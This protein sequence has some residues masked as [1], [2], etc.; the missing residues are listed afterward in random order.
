MKTPKTVILLLV[1]LL[2]LLPSAM[3]QSSGGTHDHRAVP[4]P[5]E[6][7]PQAIDRGQLSAQPG[8]SNI[9]VTLALS[10]RN[11]NDAENLLQAIN[12]PGNPRYQQFLTSDQFVAR[13]APADA[14][15]AR[16][17]A[18]LAKFGL[19]AQRTS[20]MTLSVTG[21]AANMERVFS[22]N[23]HSYEVPAHGRAAGYTY[24]APLNAPAIPADF[25]GAVTAVTGLDNRPAFRPRH[26]GVP[27]AVA[28]ARPAHAPKPS[29]TTTNDPGFLT[30]A[31]FAA[32]YDVQPLYNRGVTGKGRTLAIVT[33]AAF[34]PADAFAYWSAVGL[35][36]NANRIKIVNV[37]GGPG[38]PSDDSGSDETTL[39]VEQAGGIAPGANIIVY[40]APNTSQAFLDAFVQAVESNTAQSISTS[41]GEWEW[42]D[43][44]DNSPVTDP[45]TGK[46]VGFAQ[47]T[48]EVFLRAA[49][50]GQSVFAA[51]GDAGAYDVNR[52]CLPPD[53]T[54]TLSVDYPASDTLI[55]AAGGTTLPGLQE[56]CL[57][58][59]C[60]PPYF[61]INIQH[62]SVWGWD[63]LT[64]LCSTLGFDPISCG[65]FPAGGGGGVS[66]LF[67]RPLYQLFM[68]GMKNT[69]PNPVLTFEGELVFAV[70]ARYPGRNLP[71][72]SFNADPN[73]GY[74]IYY[75]SD[76]AGPIILTFIGGTSFVAP[77]LNGVTALL[78]DSL[79]GRRL[80]LLN[81]PLYLLALTGQAYRGAHPPMHAIAFGDNWFYKG[82]NGYNQ[83]AGLGT[84]DVANF[85][86]ALEFPF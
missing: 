53:C 6:R 64:N 86:K 68:P 33:L 34:T 10:L 20:A 54:V 11:V 15:V 74:I 70:P 84:L 4:Y 16:L 51:A 78:G 62:E 32:L 2:G 56:Y 23:L 82:T 61:D 36:V 41:W 42:F 24:H 9:S 26:Q 19:T 79:H 49:L 7:T 3:A 18:R 69:E 43:I 57:N 76:V 28:Q 38:A 40:Q 55:T 1:M 29:T 77:Q 17:V 14:D 52:G 71:D 75:T 35:T 27:Q 66:F 63:Y 85:A 12:T 44:K 72:I 46:T 37:D 81:Y 31:D 73:T 45:F 65:I 47:A 8:V 83:G 48:H 39:D 50:Q 59:A 21:S 60:T 25:S 22:V 58:A 13:F 80:G 5:S 30:T 67:P